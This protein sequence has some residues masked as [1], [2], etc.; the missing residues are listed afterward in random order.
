MRTSELLLTIEA[1]T[2]LAHLLILHPQ[3]HRPV[4]TIQMRP[5]RSQKKRL[6]S[7][8]YQRYLRRGNDILKGSEI[9]HRKQEVG[10]LY[11]G[12]HLV[13]KDLID[14]FEACKWKIA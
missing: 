2:P 1:L 8:F 13:E 11:Y 9:K 5:F 10:G 3:C 4:G 12:G 6:D 7:R 14:E